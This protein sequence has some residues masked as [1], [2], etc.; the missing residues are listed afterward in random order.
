[1]TSD[2]FASEM[3]AQFHAAAVMDTIFAASLSGGFIATFLVAGL[4]I[5]IGCTAKS[6]SFAENVGFLVGII[7]A[8]LSLVF[9]ILSAVHISISMGSWTAW[10]T[11]KA[12]PMS[13][14]V[15]NYSSAQLRAAGVDV[16][17][18]V[19]WELEKGEQNDGDDED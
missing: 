3:V 8:I 10:S 6:E 1:M 9:L 2:Q 15:Q 4:F 19:D 5:A 12:A 11:A 7:S 17:D 16:P 14:M 18:G 13:A